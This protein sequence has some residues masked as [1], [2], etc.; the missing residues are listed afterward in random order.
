MRGASIL[1]EQ[2]RDSIRLLDVAGILRGAKSQTELLSLWDFYAEH[3]RGEVR[4]ALQDVFKEKL[5]SW[6]ALHG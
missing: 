1:R 5:R 6:G 2:L 4:E 3:E